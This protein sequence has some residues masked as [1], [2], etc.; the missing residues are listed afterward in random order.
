MNVRRCEKMNKHTSSV[1]L[2][3]GHIEDAKVI[4]ALKI[5]GDIINADCK[6]CSYEGKN[7]VVRLIQS[8]NDL[9]NRQQAEIKQL[10]TIERVATKTI[11]KQDAEIERLK[12]E[13]H[14]F[15]DLGKTYSE[16]RA[17]AIKEFAERLCE[18]RVSNDPVVIAVKTELKV[19][20]VKNNG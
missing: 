19:T 15:A 14:Q 9:I 18:G 7:C 10:E 8:T 12:K 3:N 2:I 4:K 17:E 6:E 20:E 13:N 5:C 1:S 16:V 11:E